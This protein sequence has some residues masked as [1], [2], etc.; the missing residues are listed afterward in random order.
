M[1]LLKKLGK[2]SLWQKLLL[3]CVLWLAM[4]SVPTLSYWKEIS[5]QIGI[6]RYEQ[7][8]L[9]PAQLMLD[10]MQRTQ[11][12]RSLTAAYLQEDASLKNSPLKKERRAK[13]EELQEVIVVLEDYSRKI[14]NVK[15]EKT[16]ENITADW[17]QISQ[18]VTVREL[19][20]EQNFHMHQLL[21][22]KQ[23]DALQ[24][25]L[26][27]YQLSRDAEPAGYYLIS[28]SLM[29]LPS[30]V[31]VAAQL[32]AAG[33]VILTQGE[34]SFSDR[35]DLKTLLVL[36]RGKLVE[37]DSGIAK[38]VAVA[39][40]AS[41]NGSDS[42]PERYRQ[43]RQQYQALLD[44]TQ[45]EIL[46]KASFSYT[47]EEF[48]AQSWQA[49]NAYYDFIRLSIGQIDSALKDRIALKQRAI[50]K[51]F[52]MIFLLTGLVVF[53]YL[54]VVERLLRQLG[55]EPGYAIAVVQAIGRGELNH[56]IVAGNRS[57]L[58]ANLK[59]MQGKLKEERLKGAK[60]HQP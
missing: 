18:L 5:R 29:A 58:L 41:A 31:E 34:A 26:D 44:K 60:H 13:A 16:L 32:N 20:V 36:G 2:F 27:S 35:V 6:Y 59:I 52:M 48:N 21:M 49:I 1:K 46:S 42:L 47:R 54:F 51:F 9:V 25:I 3:L 28:S 14:K 57:S 12:H 22:R 55:G 30:L 15:I 37:L 24:M 40:P 53:I 45:E 17:H 19:S 10:I 43:T 39:P 23:L 33:G 50:D 56:N 4:L 38:A 8:G 7:Q 11:Q